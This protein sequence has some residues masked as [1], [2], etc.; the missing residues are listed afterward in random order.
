MLEANQEYLHLFSSCSLLAMED[1]WYFEEHKQ[2]LGSV[3][4]QAVSNNLEDSQTRIKTLQ[5]SANM[6]KLENKPLDIS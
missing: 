2:Q 3:N 1:P 6:P 4:G 5:K